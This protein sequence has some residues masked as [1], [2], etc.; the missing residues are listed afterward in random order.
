M[1]DHEIS[2]PSNIFSSIR[3]FSSQ[4]KKYFRL[5]YRILGPTPSH[6]LYSK[7]RY[8]SLAI[9]S[10][11]KSIEEASEKAA[12]YNIPLLEIVI[13]NEEEEEIVKTQLFLCFE[14]ARCLVCQSIFRINHF[15]CMGRLRNLDSPS[16]RAI[17]YLKLGSMNMIDA[18]SKI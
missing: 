13:T 18:S 3:N 9:L 15:C 1:D 14:V 12:S 16:H 10:D 6:N 5:C 2:E 17:W 4:V 11:C 8:Q 7:Y